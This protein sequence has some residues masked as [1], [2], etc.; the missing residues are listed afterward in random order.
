MFKQEP[1]IRTTKILKTYK[2]LFLL[3]NP[4]LLWRNAFVMLE[5]TKK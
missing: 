5:N 2:Q 4:V 3:S 1:G